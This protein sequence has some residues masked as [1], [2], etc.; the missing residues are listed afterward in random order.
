MTSFTLKIIALVSM[1]L[2]HISYLIFGGY[3]F[4]NLLGRIAFPIFAFQIS[5]GFIHTKSVKKYMLRLGLFALISQ[6]PYQL[7]HYKYID[8]SSIALNVFFTLLLGLVAIWIYDWLKKRFENSSKNKYHL[9]VILGIIISCFIGYI[10]KLI[11]TDYDFWGVIIIFMFYL[12][13]ENKLAMIISFI[14]LCIMK[15]GYR[16][17]IYGFNTPTLLLGIFT[18][19]S[20]IFISLYKGKQGKKIKYLLYF[21]YP[22]HLL[23]LYLLF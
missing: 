1:F 8:S 16:L 14:T 23:L 4:L 6:I 10:A 15:Y 12:F 7:F 2:D 18:I 22:V 21:F 5:E 3:S 9:E 20:I 19:L 11:H 13:K 17:I